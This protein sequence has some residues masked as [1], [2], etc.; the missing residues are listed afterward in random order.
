MI[1]KIG[2][3]V[4]VCSLNPTAPSGDVFA[5]AVQLKA[6]GEILDVSKDLS[7]SGPWVVDRDGDGKL[8]LIVTSIMGKFRWYKNVGTDVAPS[9]EHKGLVK[10]GG[11]ELKL[12]NW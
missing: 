10:V 5:K 6:D 1:L 2:F 11:E 9:Y 3:A 7:Y 4:F 12:N 8:D